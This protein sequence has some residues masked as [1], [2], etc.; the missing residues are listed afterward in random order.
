MKSINKLFLSSLIL[1]LLVCCKK[2]EETIQVLSVD[3]TEWTAESSGGKIAI[4]VNSTSDWT[5]S[6]DACWLNLSTK[7]GVSG[8]VEISLR[9]SENFSGD[10][11]RA[12]VRFESEG[13]EAIV[14][15]SQKR[16]LVLELG[17][18]DYT[19]EAEGGEVSVDLLTNLE[20]EII[21]EEGKE[22]IHFLDTKGIAEYSHKMQI[23]ANNTKTPRIGKIYIVNASDSIS[24]TIIVYQKSLPD[25]FRL[26]FT[27]DELVSP[28]LT[29]ENTIGVVE[30]G[31]LHT[32]TIGEMELIVHKYESIDTRN[33]KVKMDNAKTFELINLIGI[34]ELDF[35][36]FD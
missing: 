5:A 8:N 30:W 6:T 35:S 11:R 13:L 36:E 17:A 10:E 28:Y 22:W 34:S 19:V 25:I 18:A 27:G 23:D 14:A 9:A 2:E 26:V 7:K 12:N 1:C 16:N 20:Y 3:V 15:V 24:Q 32:D 21:V 4:T 29:G 31:D 33:V